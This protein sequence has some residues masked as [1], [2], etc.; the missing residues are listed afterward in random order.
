[1]VIAA[2]FVEELKMLHSGSE[3]PLCELAVA[4][5]IMEMCSRG[6]LWKETEEVVLRNGRLYLTSLESNTNVSLTFNVFVHGTR[7]R[8][9]PSEAW[10]YDPEEDTLM[11]TPGYALYDDTIPLDVEYTVIPTVNCR[12]YPDKFYEQY[13]GT[14]IAGASAYLK[15]IPNRP[16]SDRDVGEYERKRFIQQIGTLRSR[17]RT[18]HMHDKRSWRFR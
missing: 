17:E 12:T 9:L 10:E 3:A 5:T 6:N 11:L 15:V 16:W 1:M 18:N 7:R 8:L 4:N 13:Y 2:V 14:V